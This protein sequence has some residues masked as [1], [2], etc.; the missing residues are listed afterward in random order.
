MA[1]IEAI[2]QRM[3]FIGRLFVQSVNECDLP[4]GCGRLNL[5]CPMVATG[6]ALHPKIKR[7]TASLDVD[8]IEAKSDSLV[9][10]TERLHSIGAHVEPLTAAPSSGHI[11]GSLIRELMA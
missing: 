8:T 9:E 7:S 4:T 6:S 5:S 2:K 11:G 1:L 10:H 3:E